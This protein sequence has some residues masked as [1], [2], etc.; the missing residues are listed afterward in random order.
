MDSPPPRDPLLRVS[1]QPGGDEGC[2]IVRYESATSDLVDVEELLNDHEQVLRDIGKLEHHE[3]LLEQKKLA[4]LGGGG[5]APAADGDGTTAATALALLARESSKTKMIKE[6][7]L[8]PTSGTPCML[9]ISALVRPTPD[10]G[11]SS[12]C[13]SRSAARL[14]TQ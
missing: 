8:A 14:K 13:L 1:I 11:H 3:F 5:S 4:G 7:L 6:L 2:K 12:N 10:S 9:G